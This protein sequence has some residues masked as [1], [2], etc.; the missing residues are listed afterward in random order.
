[1]ART[2][3]KAVEP[4]EKPKKA[5]RFT[6]E[7]LLSSPT[8]SARRDVVNAVLAPGK[9]YTIAEVNEAINKFYERRVK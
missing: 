3:K 4:A 2:T 1:M 8:F 5:P 9:T 6:V 7:Q